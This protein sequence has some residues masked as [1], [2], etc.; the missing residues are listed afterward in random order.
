MTLGI[1][2]SDGE[3][4]EALREALHVAAMEPSGWSAALHALAR[5]V[6]G[7]AARA[8]G[9]ITPVDGPAPGVGWLLWVAPWVGDVW[10]RG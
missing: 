1:G 6:A 8:V 2:M 10:H 3:R 4:E 5:F 9:A 7:D